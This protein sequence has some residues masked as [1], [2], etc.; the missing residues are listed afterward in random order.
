MIRLYRAANLPEAHLIKDLL[1][2]EGIE[3][4]VFNENAQSGAG[5]LPLT[6]IYPEVWVAKDR[7]LANAKSVVQQFEKSPPSPGAADRGCATCGQLNP[8]GFEICWNCQ[9]SI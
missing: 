2:Q 8:A 5:Q 1:A 3:S 7:D 4:F 6:E 9:A